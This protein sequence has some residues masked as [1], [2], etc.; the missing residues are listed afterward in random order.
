MGSLTDFRLA[1]Q[2]QLADDLSIMFVPGRLVGPIEGRDLGSVY[3][4]R[5]SEVSGHVLEQDVLAIVRVFRALREPTD[6]QVPY[7]PAPLEELVDMLQASIKAHQ[8]G[9]GVWYQRLISAD[10]DPE[11]QGVEAVI[12]GRTANAGV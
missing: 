5:I 3:A 6:P 7:D 4:E 11:L 9:L 1:L 8:T 10:V 12:V 2:Q